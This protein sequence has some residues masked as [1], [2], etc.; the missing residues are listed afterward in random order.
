MTLLFLPLLAA[1]GPTWSDAQSQV[2]PNLELTT[3]IPERTL[4]FEVVLY[5][6]SSRYMDAFVYGGVAA[7]WAGSGA[8]RAFYGGVELAPAPEQGSGSLILSELEASCAEDGFV[9]CVIAGEVTFELLQGEAV[10]LT[11]FLDFGG[12]LS[13]PPAEKLDTASVTGTW[14]PAEG[15]G[16]AP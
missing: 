16:D 12:D 8:V 7:E 1:C 11:P 9:E 10:T 13:S 2:G 14:L 4:P 3:Q 6:E 5:A 15:P